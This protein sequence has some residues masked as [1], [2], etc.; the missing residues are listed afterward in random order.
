MRKFLSA[1]L[2]D[3]CGFFGALFMAIG[4]FT[5]IS[6]CISLH[7]NLPLMFSAAL[8]SVIFFLIGA[9]LY[10]KSALR[11]RRDAA[12]VEQGYNVSGQ[13]LE[14]RRSIF[15]VSF[16]FTAG[17]ADHPYVISYQYTVDGTTYTGKTPLLW[18]QPS[19]SHR[20][21]AKVFIDPKHP[22]RSAL[23]YQVL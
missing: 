5:F 18:K 10:A 3:L 13:V 8:P 11:L 16:K 17:L 21:Q 22:A 2:S 15:K 19:Q 12:L 14:I 6:I 7:S 23:K 9:A 20:K 1:V 4:L